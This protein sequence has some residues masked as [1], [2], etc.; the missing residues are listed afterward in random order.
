MTWQCCQLLFGLMAW[1]ASRRARR[2]RRRAAV[3][4]PSSPVLITLKPSWL[5]LKP[6]PPPP[7]LALLPLRSPWLPLTSFH[8]ILPSRLCRP[9]QL[10]R[11]LPRPQQPSPPL[12]PWPARARS[13]ARRRSRRPSGWATLLI[14]KIVHP[15][16]VPAHAAREGAANKQAD[17]E[18]AEAALTTA[19]VNARFAVPYLPTLV[20]PLHLLLTCRQQRRPRRRPG[21]LFVFHS[22]ADFS[23]LPCSPAGSRGGR[24]AGLGG[25]RA[26]HAQRRQEDA[27]RGNAQGL[28]AQGGGGSLVR[29]RCLFKFDF[30]LTAEMPKGYVP[31]AVE[32]AW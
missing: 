19:W 15:V 26:R 6:M 11:P 5:A 30:L 8:L 21:C 24:G 20:A 22:S 1:H 13:R 31:K 29:W 14:R 7:L 27:A 4:S 25:R 32:A 3:G 18:A 16:P 28:C 23:S 12:P 2:P 9:A 10:P 17:T